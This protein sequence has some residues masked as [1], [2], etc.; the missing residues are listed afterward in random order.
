[1]IG[2]GIARQGYPIMCSNDHIGKVS[3]GGYAPTLDTNI[4]MGYVP[5][6][7]SALGTSF[8]IDIR[9]RFVEAE[10]VNL[11]FYSRGKLS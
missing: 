1:M 5:I 9:G 3:S 8:T 4:G 6:E 2:R 10:V 7:F 11:P